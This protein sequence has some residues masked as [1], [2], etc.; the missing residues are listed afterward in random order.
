MKIINLLFIF[1][2]PLT[3]CT[4]PHL[5]IELANRQN[6]IDGLSISFDIYLRALTGYSGDNDNWQGLSATFDIVSAADISSANGTVDNANALSLS[7][8][9]SIPGSSGNNKDFRI[10]ASRNN[11]PELVINSPAKIGTITIAV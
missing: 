11:Q 10:N 1:L 6:S 5:S 8:T 7:A 4:Q 9:T 2:L 3:L